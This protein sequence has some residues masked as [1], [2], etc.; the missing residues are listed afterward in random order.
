[1]IFG[2]SPMPS[3]SSSSGTQASDGTARSAWTVGREQR[4]RRRGQPDQAAERQAGADADGEADQHPLGADREVL[5]QLAAAD[6]LAQRGQHVVR[7]RAAA[8]RE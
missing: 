8:P 4:A 1:M 7:R 2:V 5:P 3:Q 6:Q